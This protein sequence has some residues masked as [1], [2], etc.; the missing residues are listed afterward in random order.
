MTS[1]VFSFADNH[2]QRRDFYPR[3]AGDGIPDLFTHLPCLWFVS[4]V[5]CYRQYPCFIC[6]F[7]LFVIAS[8][9]VIILVTNI[10]MMIVISKIIIYI[11]ISSFSLGDSP[12]PISMIICI[13]FKVLITEN[14]TLACR[15][16]P[17]HRSILLQ[18]FVHP[19]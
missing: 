9:H 18:C 14:L 1:S 4:V 11:V 2:H 13:V 8:I 5:I 6:L 12:F 7:V 19:L 16:E 10:L 15:S 17:L 3:A